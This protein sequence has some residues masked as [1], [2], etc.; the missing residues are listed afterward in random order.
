MELDEEDKSDDVADENVD[1]VEGTVDDMT[2]IVPFEWS[3]SIT[4]IGRFRQY[5]TKPRLFQIIDEDPVKKMENQLIEESC[6][7]YHREFLKKTKH[8]LWLNQD[9]FIILSFKKSK[10]VYPKKASQSGMNPEHLQL[11]KKECDKL[12]EFGLI[13]PSDSHWSCEVFYVNK[14]AEQTRGKLCLVIN[15]QPLNHFRLN[16]KFPIPNKLTLFSHLAK[17]IHFSKFD[18]KFRFWKLGIHLEDRSKMAF[19]I[20]DHH[21]Q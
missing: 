8:S 11:T 20:P 4:F 7:E 10:N 15:Y 1:E 19:C 14:H 5:S 13:Q 6:T 17:D 2:A 16:D 3:G 18:L 12:L 21:Y 9:F